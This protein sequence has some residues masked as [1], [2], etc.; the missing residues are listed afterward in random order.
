MQ[1]SFWAMAIRN[2]TRVTD[3][4]ALRPPEKS[5]RRDRALLIGRAVLITSGGAWKV[6]CMCR[7][8]QWGPSSPHTPGGAPRPARMHRPADAKGLAGRKSWVRP[9]KL[10]ELCVHSADRRTVPS[11]EGG[12]LWGRPPPHCWLTGT[13]GKVSYL[14]MYVFIYL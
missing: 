9:V 1:V 5:G 6:A 11:G 12:S 14:C 13:S 2:Q 10:P 8:A 4:L 3:D 7:R